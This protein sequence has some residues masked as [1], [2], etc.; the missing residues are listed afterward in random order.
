MDKY[1]KALFLMKMVSLSKSP[2][3]RRFGAVHSL[4]QPAGIGPLSLR[5]VALLLLVTYLLAFPVSAHSD[6]VAASVAYG[7]LG[8]IST[9]VI[10]VTIQGLIL[11]RRLNIAV[12][13]PS[14]ETAPGEVIK[15]AVIIPR[16]RILPLSSLDVTL[17]SPCA[18]F[19]GETL[20]IYGSSARERRLHMEV[21]L[22][23]RGSWTV[24]S[25]ECAVRDVAGLS[26]LAWSQQLSSSI[27][28]APTVG[29]ETRLPLISSTQRPGE[30]VTDV[31]NRQGDPFD[32]KPYHPSDGIKKIIWKVFAKRGELLS[33]HPEASMT[34]E[35]FVVMMVLAR[36]LDDDVCSLALTYAQS[37]S[38]L[39]LDIVLSCEGAKGRAPALAV[40]SAKTM[41]I[42]SV[43]DC[44][45]L[46]GK[47]LLTD[48]V[49]LLD[50]CAN[51]ALK[52]QVRKLIIFCAGDR[53]ATPDGAKLILDLASWLNLQGVEPIFCLTQPSQLRHETSKTLTARALP[54][55]L[56]PGAE[57]LKSVS[58]SSFQRFLSDCLS[59]QWEVFV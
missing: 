54:L 13:P 18:G 9:A 41:L 58:A 26:R 47:S 51:H 6:I 39:N 20:R 17:K 30:L 5:C 33:R 50:F 24:S 19:P 43:W 55:F 14:G 2:L 38:E 40:D 7:L 45:E 52:T 3:L 22:P 12:I 56:A 16:L 31:N 57:E 35:G 28:V 48:T 8:I 59:K 11:Q 36:S 10:A 25:I 15:I 49:A 34:P 46:Q 1:H 27:E 29:R 4:A 37:V 21:A 44:E 23:H 53:V 32:I 42:D